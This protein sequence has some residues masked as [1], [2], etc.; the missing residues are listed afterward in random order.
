MYLE[1]FLHLVQVGNLGGETTSIME[2]VE[3]L[4][5]SPINHLDVEAL[6]RKLLFLLVDKYSSLSWDIVKYVGLN[7]DKIEENIW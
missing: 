7:R 2:V 1:D 6:R 3:D 5:F 4:R